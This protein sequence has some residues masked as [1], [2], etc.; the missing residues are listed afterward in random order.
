MPDGE[1]LISCSAD[2]SIRAWD[3]V[4]GEQT[5]KMNE[6]SGIVNACSP[7]RRGSPLLVSASDDRT[8]RVWDLRAKRSVRT[9]RDRYQLLAVAFA[10]AGDAIYAGGTENV[11][12]CWDLRR[13]DEPS[14]ELEGH[15]DTIT[16]LKLSP[17]G[18]HLLSNSM[19]N[20]LRVWDV[21]PYAPP[22]RCEH[23]MT[24]HVHDFQKNLLRCDWS[25][26]GKRVV[27]GSADRV[28]CIWSASSGEMQYRLPGHSGSVNAVAFHP[29]EPIVGSGSSDKT[30][31]LGEL[32]E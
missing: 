24:G 25:P 1:R 5:K 14:M 23:V 28:V 18:A 17:D 12:R 3:A 7:A 19:D 32:A 30:I 27:A 9:I 29:S 22:V 2:A 31:Y 8:A 4:T 11:V 20:T 13:D 26:D 16:G 6:H 10:E 21:R 15:G